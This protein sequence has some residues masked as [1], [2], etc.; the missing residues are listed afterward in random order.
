LPLVETAIASNN[1]AIA[2]SVNAIT[3]LAGGDLANKK[4][5]VW[6]IAFKA[7][8]DDIRDS[9]ALKIVDSLISKGA[10]VQAYDPVA[11][12]PERAGF[13]LKGLRIRSCSRC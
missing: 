1:A 7:N 13:V 10:E 11:V 3:K 4:V 8:T 12:A 6:G 5:A 2:R 9:P